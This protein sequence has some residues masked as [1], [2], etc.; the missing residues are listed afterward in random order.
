LR[1]QIQSLQPIGFGAISH[2]QQGTG[3]Q[4]KETIEDKLKV[5]PAGLPQ[6]ADM[7]FFTK[8]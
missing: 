4:L 8:A 1:I 7:L 6:R 3:S 5:P 2:G